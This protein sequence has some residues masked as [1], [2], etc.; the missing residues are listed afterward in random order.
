MRPYSEVW[1][2]SGGYSVLSSVVIG[3]YRSTVPTVPEP[4]MRGERVSKTQCTSNCVALEALAR[5]KQ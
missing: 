3:W 4:P 2:A 1:T 5:N